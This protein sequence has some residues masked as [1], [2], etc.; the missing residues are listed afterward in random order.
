[1]NSGAS[2]G[3]NGLVDFGPF[4]MDGFVSLPGN[5]C[6]LPVKVLSD[7]VSSQSFILAGVLTLGQD[8]AVGSD[9]GQ[10]WVL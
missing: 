8:S 6:V 3:A 2:V 5:S 7:T 9:V 4:V 10:C 1:M